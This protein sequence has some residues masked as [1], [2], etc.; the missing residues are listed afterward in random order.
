MSQESR[1]DDE[2]ALPTG[3]TSATRIVRAQIRLLRLLTKHTAA[4]IRSTAIHSRSEHRQNSLQNV[5]R[6]KPS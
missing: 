6:A 4:S 2:L 5:M 3:R 1:K